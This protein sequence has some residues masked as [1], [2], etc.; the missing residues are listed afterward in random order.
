MRFAMGYWHWFFLAQPYDFPERII[1]A[2]PD[3][4]FLNRP[5]R[6]SVFSPE[7][8][9][10]YLRCYRDA[11]TVHAMCEDYR[12]AATYDYALDEA[13]RGHRKIAAPLLALWAGNGQVGAW[14]DVLEV[15]R[16]WAQDVR[17]QAI[18]AGHFMA[19]EAPDATYAA[20]RAFFA[21]S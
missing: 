17:G 3:A 10:E 19:E 20:L 1:G 21:G 6:Q 11:R 15:W 5:H 7:A 16:D 2:D 9:A 8:L 18:A 12:A 4:F 13:D 14:Y